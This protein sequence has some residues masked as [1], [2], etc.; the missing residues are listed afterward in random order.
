MKKLFL[1]NAFFLLISVNILAQSGDYTNNS[2]L[3][4]EY[5][6]IN[7]KSP[8]VQNFS[9][10][11]FSNFNESTGKA[12]IEIP[13]YTINLDGL[14]IPVKLKYDI[15]GVKVN[16]Q[17]SRVGL[18]W[19]LDSGGMIDKTVVGQNDIHTAGV[20]SDASPTG[21]VYTTYGYLFHLLQWT[22]G[23][24]HAIDEAKR[25]M[26]PDL[27]HIYAPGLNTAFFHDKTGK[28]IEISPNNT[29]IKSPFEDP[30]FLTDPWPISTVYNFEDTQYR[31][32]D[33]YDFSFDFVSNSG[34]KYKFN[35]LEYSSSLINDYN[36]EP[37]SNLPAPRTVNPSTNQV[38]ALPNI[39]FGTSTRDKFSTIYLT[40]IST[41]NSNKEVEFKYFDNKIVDN[42][43]HSEYA[44]SQ[45]YSGNPTQINYCYDY[46]REKV[47]KQ[48]IFPEGVIDFEYDY[49]RLDLR[50]GKILKRI[51]VRNKQGDFIKGILF[52]HSYFNSITGVQ[53]FSNL[54]L[55]LD[56]VKFF[57][58]NDVYLNEYRFKYNDTKLPKKFSVD[59]D[60]MG[61]YNGTTN[62]ND[63]NC[64]PKLYYK[65]NQG[66]K[67]Y[68]P[69]P[70]NGYT[71]LTNGNKDKTSNLFYSKAAILESITYPTGA[72]ENF[73]YELNS[74]LFDSQQVQGGGL[75]IKS[76]SI[77]N[78][79]STLKRKI[80]YSYV[81]G[82][83]TTS[84]TVGATPDFAY[85]LNNSGSLSRGIH[86]Y[87]QNK[88][89]M[90]SN[91]FVIYS[92]V[93]IE[94][95]GKGFTVNNYTS[96][97]DFT[98]TYPNSVFSTIGNV[99]ISN[100]SSHVADGLLTNLY[101]DNSQKRGLLLKSEIFNDNNSLIKKTENEYLTNTI[102]TYPTYDCYVTLHAR[103]AYN[104]QSSG[105]IFKRDLNIEK[106]LLSKSKISEFLNGQSLEKEIIYSYDNYSFQT[107]KVKQL[108]SPTETIETN[109]FYPNNLA[110]EPYTNDLI[111]KNMVSTPL[112]KKVLK[113]GE[114]IMVGK[115]IFDKSQA[116][117][118]FLLPKFISNKKSDNANI[119]FENV[120]TF[121]LYDD[122]CNP[123]QY[124][125]K[126][127]IPV[128]IIWGYNKTLPIAKIENATYSQIQSHV[129]SLQTITNNSNDNSSLI[130]AFNTLRSSLPNSMIT[131][132]IHQPLIG[133]TTI[134]D[135]NGRKSVFEYD[136]ANRLINSR[137]NENNL[138]VTNNYNFEITPSSVPMFQL[139]LAV[140]IV[141]STPYGTVLSPS[142]PTHSTLLSANASGGNG[143]YS[144]EWR[145]NSTSP[146]LSTSSDF[147]TTLNCGTATSYFLKVTDGN[148]NSI[149][150][151]ISVNSAACNEAFYA[152]Q[153]LGTSIANNQYDFYVDAEG[154]S[155]K[156]SYKWWAVGSITTQ[157]GTYYDNTCPKKLHNTTAS[158]YTITLHVEITDLTSG[159]KVQRNR[160]VTIYPEFSPSSCFVSGTK[161]LMSDGSSK[162]IEDIKIGDKV[163][164][165]NTE[166]NV[167]EIGEVNETVSPMHDEL[168][169]IIFNNKVENTNTLDHPYYVKNKG[170]CSYNPD[171]T[172]SNYGLQVKNIEVGDVVYFMNSKNG[173]IENIKITN[174]NV[175]HSMQK[176]FNLQKVSK[177]HN[178]FA[179]GV[180]VHNKS[181]V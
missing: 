119:A 135:A 39:S 158:S 138:T 20:F 36:E 157:L 139:P 42:N 81:L 160:V 76:Q 92:Q 141:K 56:A 78:T 150:K 40:K 180:L 129:N 62:L 15:G 24:N 79:D 77:Y 25:D 133:I 16:S 9:Q 127:G 177:N 68:L 22:Y 2:S 88:D 152:S 111:S 21:F 103:P 124:T 153:I 168:I 61:Y 53:D 106:N 99:D 147:L 51:I 87:Q 73:E 130:T 171:L 66:K 3:N 7:L 159:F 75:R 54:R 156:Y 175:I 27:Y 121:D 55:K 145:L 162:N 90:D 82:N 46:I 120:M 173:I 151:T 97:F 104:D 131:C 134:I 167:I 149:N 143:S 38:S 84:G 136:T 83:G 113:N 52:E 8:E 125:E 45:N 57:D 123:I 80:N 146:I 10:V 96:Y 64:I 1:I 148:S 94:E 41:P 115:T 100:Y 32:K 98:D 74:F 101:T 164:T 179:N 105:L 142:S 144:Y 28:P 23:P 117:N 11:G 126:N 132:Y 122:K 161:I 154:G 85:S 4:F 72:F 102:S 174:I 178:F 176:T 169:T 71:A 65:A 30:N 114:I 35:N 67:S 166:K 14:E 155:Y 69:F 89:I 26:H 37:Y 91:P 118:N 108:N 43:Q 128:S 170:W 116:T 31:F 181:K 49:N 5:S 140:E 59:Q 109:Y 110:S 34:F 172:M 70:V 33:G 29:I 165:Y 60:Y 163:K 95:I 19:T 58:K 50:G 112:I 44:F 12:N 93:K 18:N 48:I 86:Q 47:L 13:L 17:S 107:S 137:D 63:N 6:D